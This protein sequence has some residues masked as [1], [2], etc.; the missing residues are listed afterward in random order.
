MVILV[1]TN[2]SL[3]VRVFHVAPRTPAPVLMRIW[4]CAFAVL[5]AARLYV[6]N[7]TNNIRHDRCIKGWLIPH[8][9]GLSDNL[10]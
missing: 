7:I 2:V 10:L 1:Y 8:L 3:P 5:V 9:Y 6:L 4:A